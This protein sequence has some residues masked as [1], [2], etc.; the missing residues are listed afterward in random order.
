M[1]EFHDPDLRNQL[2]QLSGPYPDDNVAF[3]AWQRR[4]GQARRRRAV[5]LTTGAALSLLFGTVAVAALKSPGRHTLV[6]SK[7]ADST[8][9]SIST[10]E[11][12][13]SSTI[14][15]TAPSTTDSTVVDTTPVTEVADTS[16][17][18]TEVE[19][20]DAAGGGSN[21]GSGK[22]H[23]TPTSATPGP[24]AGTKTFSSP[25][26]TITVSQNGDQLTIVA[27]HAAPGFSGKQDEGSG[28][29]VGA[30]FKS[31]N[32]E[33]QI[34]VRVVNGVMQD[35]VSPKD[36]NHDNSVPDNTENASGNDTHNS[37]D[38]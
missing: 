7:A 8:E 20:T 4:V 24:A 19:V 28:R 12:E 1:S 25:G 36:R 17:P 34:S 18:E 3:A 14:E 38:D 16:V 37:G 21:S 15:S 11:P 29:R 31:D 27:M 23:G 35:N 6:P 26:G 5:A 10:T 30:T 33:W 13:D 22:Q 9:L 32:Q 2:G